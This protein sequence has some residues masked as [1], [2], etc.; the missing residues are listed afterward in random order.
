[1]ER[2]QPDPRGLVLVGTAGSQGRMVEK[3]AGS[4]KRA[5]ELEEFA[6]VLEPVFS[7][8]GLTIARMACSFARGF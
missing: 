6:E 4:V 8:L 1:M 7:R 3:V 5:G 2:H